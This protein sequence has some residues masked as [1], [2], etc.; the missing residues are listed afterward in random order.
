MLHAISVSLLTL[1]SLSAGIWVIVVLFLMSGILVFFAQEQES[2]SI[3]MWVFSPEH[4]AMYLPMIESEVKAENKD[5]L[6]LSLLSI[7]AIK[8]R[9]MSGFFG[10]LPTADLIEVERSTVGQAFMGPIDAIGFRD[11]TEQL[12]REG[13]LELFNPPSL[14]PWSVQGRVFG[15]PHDVHP[16]MLAYRADLV[17]EAGIDLEQVETWEDFFRLL[18]PMTADSDGDGQPDRHAMSFWFTQQDNIELLLLQGGGQLFDQSGVPTISSGR[19][20]ELLSTIVSWC[21]DPAQPVI[22]ID[23]FSAAGHQARIDG[24]AIAYLC[25]DWM[26]SIWKMHVPLIAGKMKLIPLPAFEPGGRRT[27]VRGGTMLGFPRTSE[28]FDQAWQSAKL[29]YTSPEIARELYR[30]VDI[31]SPVR[32]LW[33]DPVYDEPDPFFMNQAKGQMY[34]DLAPTIPVRSSSPYNHSAVLEIRDAA[35]NLAKWAQSNDVYESEDLIGQAEV[36]LHR[37][38]ENIV[39]QMSRNAFTGVEN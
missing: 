5:D 17:E 14:S 4:Q 23:E 28:H 11:I 35:V 8:S 22:D 6:H 9:M 21:V 30:M 20:S 26:C 15:L 25:P 13:M 18:A 32:S 38:Q 36:L 34:I 7:A 33:D 37:A 27:S 31:I 2:D 16:V 24:K 3:E 39:R 29:L 19:N 10:G 1:R 12:K